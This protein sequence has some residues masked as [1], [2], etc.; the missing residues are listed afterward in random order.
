MVGFQQKKVDHNDEKLASP[1]TAACHY[2]GAAPLLTMTQWYRIT[3]Q[4]GH[5]VRL[6][7]GFHSSQDDAG[8]NCHLKFSI[9]VG[10]LGGAA[11]ELNRWRFHRWAPSPAVLYSILQLARYCR[12]SFFI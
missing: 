9:K 3:Q 7:D 10:F 1:D 5:V 11:S 12:R 4:A 6:P 2:L 8:T